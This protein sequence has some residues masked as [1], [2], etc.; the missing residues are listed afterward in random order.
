MLRRFLTL[1]LVLLLGLPAAAAA[2][3]FTVT[4]SVVE[5]R[6]SEPTTNADGSPLADLAHT[7]VFFQFPGQ[8]PVKGPNVP[9]SA[10]TGA[11][12]ILT[13]VTVPVVAGQEADVTFWATATD[14]SANESVRSTEFVKRIDRLP[15][16][17]PQ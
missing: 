2:I 3:T 11:G 13:T 15:P 14:T 8:A 7:N 6:Y 12:A 1:T 10:L 4:G 5:A 9:A 16:G 17:A